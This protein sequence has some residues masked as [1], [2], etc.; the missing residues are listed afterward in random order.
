MS[1][2]TFAGDAGTQRRKSP[3]LHPHAREGGRLLL[4]ETRETWKR[5][6]VAGLS[7]TNARLRRANLTIAQQLLDRR[8]ARW[9]TRIEAE[10]QTGKPT[11]IVAGAGHFSGR[12][13][14]IAL[15][16][17]HGYTLEQL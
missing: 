5:G 14:V 17:E 2:S 16:K 8:N 12:G 4:D 6:D 9:V 15:L 1:M 3:S 13:S 7:A 11:A 10:M